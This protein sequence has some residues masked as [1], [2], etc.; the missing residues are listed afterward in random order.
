MD[1]SYNDVGY[2][3]TKAIAE[4][5]EINTTLTTLNFS[6]CNMSVS[7]SKLIEKALEINTTINAFF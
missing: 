7:W 1:I 4:T 6:Y 5:I 2:Y 3:G